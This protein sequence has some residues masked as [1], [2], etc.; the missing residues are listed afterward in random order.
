MR[1]RGA[2]LVRSAHAPGSFWSN[3]VFAGTP[4]EQV[5]REIKF[6]Q[7]ACYAVTKEAILARPRDFWERL[8]K[9][10]EDLGEKNPEEGHYME[11]M[12][13][14]VFAPDVAVVQRE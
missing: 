1:R 11:R 13:Y 12:W 7:G 4:D 8:L 5:P 10:F 6:V 3:V 14:A 2:T 9:Y